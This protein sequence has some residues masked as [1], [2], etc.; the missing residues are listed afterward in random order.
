MLVSKTLIFTTNDFDEA[1]K[2]IAR[3]L[4]NDFTIT[5]VEPY[6]FLISAQGRSKV[7]AV[8]LKNRKY[9]S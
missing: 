6:D 1:I 4:D 3:E 7:V 8:T 5:K 2:T 9:D